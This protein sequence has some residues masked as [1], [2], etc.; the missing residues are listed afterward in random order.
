MST[1][2]GGPDRWLLET[3]V[4][5]VGGHSP[6]WQI[7]PA[8]DPLQPWISAAPRDRA[9]PRQGWK[10][11]VSSYASTAAE[12][13]RRALP[14]L[15]ATGAAFKVLGSLDWLAGLN[16]GAAGISQIGKFITAYPRDEDEAL[17]A[18]AAVQAA[19][20]GMRG[21]RIPSDLAYADGSVV[22][23][24]YG[25]FSDTRMQTRLGEVVL[26]VLDPAGRL[27]PDVRGATPHV[28][29]WVDDPFRRNGL[30]TSHPLARTVAGR[31]RPIVTLAHSPEAVVQLALDLAVPRVCVL[32]RARTRPAD[33][34]VEVDDGALLLRRE[35][36][37]LARLASQR[38][39]PAVL[40][41]VESE[42]EL[43]LVSEDLG[44]ETLDRY[45]RTL[46]GTGRV[47]S[48]ARTVELGAAI[49]ESV[50]ALHAIG[51]VHG[52]L[53]SAN[54][55]LRPDGAV[56]LIDFDLAHPF[57]AT[58][59]PAGAGTRGYVSPGCRAGDAVAA[60]DDIHALGA[61]LYLLATG[62][63]PSRAPDADDL[64]SRPLGRLNPSVDGALAAVVSR[65]LA[66]DPARR[67]PSMREVRRALL[68]VTEP[69]PARVPAPPAVTGVLEPAADLL[70]LASRA[71]DFICHQADSSGQEV[72]WRS[73]YRI[74]KG[75]VGRDLDSGMAG[76]ILALAELTDE[77]RVP[78]HADVLRAA[79][80]TLDAMPPVPGDRPHGLY[81][82]DMG[83][84]AAVLRAGQVLAD[85]GLVQAAADRAAGLPQASPDDSPDL[86]HGL[87]GRLLGNLLLWDRTGDGQCL[88]RAVQCGETLLR[89]REGERG[90]AHW[91]IPPGYGDLSGRSFLGYAHGAAG[92]ADALLDLHEATGAPGY[93]A[94]ARDALSWITRQAVP[95][96]ED[97]SGLG[98]P[99]VEG[100]PATA[101]FW[102]HGA[103]GIGRL[104]LHTRR[105]GIGPDPTPVLR[106][107][108]RSVSLGA[109]W[110]GPTLCHGLAGNAELLW[111]AALALDDDGLRAQARELVGI[112]DAFA[113]ESPQGQ[114][115]I[116]D[117]PRR[118][119]PDYLVGYAGI[120]LVLLRM[121]R[122]G[123][124]YQLSREGF[125]Q[126]VGW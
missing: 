78:H 59:R 11:H 105:L 56:R 75:L 27:V 121:A 46:S 22:F 94:A 2:T 117:V 122:P 15:V 4:E 44:G 119:T 63:E 101:P 6:D 37:V 112:L 69:H 39:T 26:A 62:A 103:T 68:T 13:L 116:S 64:L 41:V 120:P 98:W 73:R 66:R 102:C 74:G 90:T 34:E 16:R 18:A 115:W 110:S 38:V 61:V 79:A 31:Y 96:L 107:A 124:R 113:T 3:V 51:H 35:I 28:P 97:G 81:V 93:E 70:Q 111:D 82:G 86:F 91:P 33:H 42:D 95:C 50:S 88:D 53:K 58:E 30:S 24:R 67:F 123:R 104:L 85:D 23:Y 43:V 80:R 125:G 47:C 49:A 12:T 109:R 29:A 7:T 71:G 54:I 9:L 1:A 52:D 40:D 45:V 60:S 77:L 126:A 48:T 57:G 20:R 72:T 21:P 118:I 55:I 19:T 114:A 8:A 106:R 99:V 17:A 100:G 89:Q 84:A 76:T 14:P 25:G 65:C 10:L 87:A 32:K 108:C 5:A 83:V 36:A 92:I